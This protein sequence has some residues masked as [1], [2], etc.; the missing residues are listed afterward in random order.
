MSTSVPAGLVAAEVLHQHPIY[1][2]IGYLHDPNDTI[3]GFS[4]PI[5]Y[6]ADQIWFV[7]QHRQVRQLMSLV[8]VEVKY[9][10]KGVVSDVL[11]PDP[12]RMQYYVDKNSIQIHLTPLANRNG[13]IP[14]RPYRRIVDDKRHP[15]GTA[16]GDS[17]GHDGYSY[18]HMLA[19]VAIDELF[20]FEGRH[21]RWWRRDT[22]HD[23]ISGAI[24]DSLI[25]LFAIGGDSDRWN[26]ELFDDS[27]AKL[28]HLMHSRMPWRRQE[29]VVTRRVFRA[30]VAKGL[31]KRG[32][33][34]NHPDLLADTGDKIKHP[35]VGI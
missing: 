3:P 25:A 27:V 32:V 4:F 35:P 13:Y 1:D 34:H 17:Y 8:G 5:T 6:R 26:R 10:D 24:G 30:L 15:V 29:R 33:T 19:R 16:N 2:E 23:E 12:V 14:R 9:N 11:A 28:G 31:E 21:T 18:D 7:Y 22:A 20:E